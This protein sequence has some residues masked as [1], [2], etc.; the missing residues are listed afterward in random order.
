ML[1]N[2]REW[3][4][5]ATVT[6]ALRLLQR[7]G[8]A[9]VPAAGMTTLAK[10]EMP[11]VTGLVDL[12]ALPLT[13]V[14]AARGG[15]RVGATT[16]VSELIDA[17]AGRKYAAGMLRQCGLSIGSTLNRNLITCGGNSVQC[18]FWSCLP[19]ALLALDAQLV[20]ARGRGRRRVAA[21]EFFARQPKQVLGAAALVTELI[22]PPLPPGTR[23][24]FRKVAPTATAFAQVTVAALL[25]VRAGT[26]TGLQA[27]LGGL[28]A[29]PQRFPE[30][31]KKYCGCPATDAVFAELAE[32]LA[33]HCQ[34]LPDM[35]VS[36]EYKRMLVQTVTGD[37]LR[38]LRDGGR[39]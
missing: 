11:A 36:A 32:R 37:L 21:A 33:S 7:G 27:A 26:I 31:E 4:R 5:P 6:A 2:L 39:S 22:L 20:V 3:H 30:L 25:R 19:V 10:L 9:V 34:V 15:L 38:A 12:T 14:N 1:V 35:R 13:Y 8:A 24:G 18:Y 23:A 29:L 17:P 28:A 16:T